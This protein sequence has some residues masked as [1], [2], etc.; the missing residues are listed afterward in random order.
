MYRTRKGKN[1]QAEKKIFKYNKAKRSMAHRQ[2]PKGS[3]G[4]VLRVV[5]EGFGGGDEIKQVG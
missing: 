3:N 4:P 2:I 5:N 1:I